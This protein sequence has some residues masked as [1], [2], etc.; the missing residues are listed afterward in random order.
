MSGG[1]K[2][3]PF[4]GSEVGI[5]QSLEREI[6]IEHADLRREAGAAADEEV[7]AVPADGERGGYASR[8][9]ND[10]RDERDAIGKI[11]EP[12]R[13]S[14]PARNDF[15]AIFRSHTHAGLQDK[16]LFLSHSGTAIREK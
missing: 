7:I 15:L 5:K 8:E 16:S 6:V 4:D 11:H 12:L 10:Q 14:H 13:P 3:H 9:A 2:I 1:V